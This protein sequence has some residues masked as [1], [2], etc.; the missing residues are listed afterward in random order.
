MI[1]EGQTVVCIASGPSLTELDCKLVEASGLKTIAVNSSW[2]IAPFC[3]VLYAGDCNFW[4]ANHKEI[5]IPA[6]R[7]SCSPYAAQKFGTHRHYIQ[8]SYNSGSRAIELAIG[9]GAS[10]ILLLGYDCSIK[11]GVHWHGKHTKTSNPTPAK[12]RSWLGHFKNVSRLA[13]DKNIKVINCSR[14][15]ALTCFVQQPLEEALLCKAVLS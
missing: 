8:G 3:D 7:W 1:W 2:K 10:T 14:Q 13:T 4:I 12:C 15:T 5:N 11:N 9:F 6:Q